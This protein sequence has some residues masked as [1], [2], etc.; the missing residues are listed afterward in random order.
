VF[1]IFH[2]KILYPKKTPNTRVKYDKNAHHDTFNDHSALPKRHDVVFTP[3]TMIASSS[4]SFVS[5]R[6]R[7]RCRAFHVVSH[8]PKDGN[9]SHG[10]SITFRMFDTSY[11]IYHENDRIV[12]TNVEPK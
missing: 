4:G 2:T 7:P 11:V 8:A 12:A 5:S 3:R 1:S 10:P 9:A 6:S